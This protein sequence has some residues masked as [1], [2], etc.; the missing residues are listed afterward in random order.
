MFRS[1]KIIIFSSISLLVVFLLVLLIITP[2]LRNIYGIFDSIL[3][4]KKDLA[5]FENEALKVEVFINDYN[6]LQ[7]TSETI[8]QR[9]VNES[10]PI[11][12][13]KFF[14][15]TA[16]ELNLSIDIS[17]TSVLAM[18]RDPWESIG[19]S[20]ELIGDF[21][22]AMRFLEKIENSPYFI[23]TTKFDA[24]L[25]TQKDVSYRRYQDFII[26]QILTTLEFK[27]YTKQ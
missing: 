20:I 11:D 4:T 24:K 10:A 19:F 23:E 12:L 14:E 18:D 8:E 13:I 21:S 6:N 27:A 3:E 5:S 9:L 22:S 15:D 2:L 26:G 16:K 1:K 17:P 25:I 7:I